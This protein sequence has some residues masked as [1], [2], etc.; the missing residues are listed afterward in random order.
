M[1]K[2]VNWRDLWQGEHLRAFAVPKAGEEPSTAP[3]LA[4]FWD[5]WVVPAGWG[6]SGT[7]RPEA[8]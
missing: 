8:E 5:K 6:V 4:A 2:R 7:G 3:L 1:S